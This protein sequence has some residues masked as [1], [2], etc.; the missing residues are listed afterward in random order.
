MNSPPQPPSRSAKGVLLVLTV[1]L[2]ACG[3]EG[4]DPPP[5]TTAVAEAKPSASTVGSASGGAAV[6]DAPK[7]PVTF[8]LVEQFAGQLES[9]VG[10]WLVGDQLVVSSHN[11]IGKIEGG[12]LEWVAKSDGAIGVAPAAARRSLSSSHPGLSVVSRRSP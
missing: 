5:D 12:K 1:A 11:R 3:S 7:A 4:K 9:P 8:E 10:V 2:T 6:V